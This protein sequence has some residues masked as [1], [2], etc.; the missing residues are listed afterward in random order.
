[1]TTQLEYR[2]EAAAEYELAF[3]HVSDHFLPTLFEAAG[4]SAGMR[5]LDIATGT[6]RGAEQIL[7]IV[8]PAGHVVAA[9]ASPAMVD[10]ARARLASKANGS[11]VVEDG[12]KLSFGPNSFDAVVCSLGLMFFPDPGSGVAQFHRVLRPGGRAAA[13]VLTVPERSYNGRINVIIA[14]HVPSLAEATKR[15]FALGDPGRLRSLFV[16]AGFGDIQIFTK[17]HRFELPS[18]DTY[19][20]PF[21]RGGGSTGQ[22]LLSLP[23]DVRRAVREEVRMSVGADRGP[24]GIDV[25]FMF[26]SGRR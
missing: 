12:Q 24:V 14:K 2:D 3:A 20:R 18:F 11:V 4:L 25:E 22:A 5:V 8:G 15:T 19:Y 13:S 16:N 6:G 7:E 9:D 23:E 21:E 17:R 1:M 10:H 26:A